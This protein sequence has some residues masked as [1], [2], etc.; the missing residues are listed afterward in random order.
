[1]SVTI[2]AGTSAGSA[3]QSG[4]VF[5]TAAIISVVSSP[6]NAPSRRST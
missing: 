3:D 5:I 2:W 1:M 4:G 6:S